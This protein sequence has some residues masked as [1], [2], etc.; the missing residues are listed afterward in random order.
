MKKNRFTRASMIC[1][2]LVAICSSIISPIIVM[3]CN[4]N[5]CKHGYHVW[6]DYYLE[7]SNGRRQG[8]KYVWISP[9]FNT[10]NGERGL[11]TTGALQWNS[12]PYITNYVKL[13]TTSNKSNAQIIIEIAEIGSG[14]LGI[15]YLKNNAL[16]EELIEV[17]HVPYYNFEG[18]VIRL[19]KGDMINNI[20]WL[21]STTTHEVG[22]ALGLGHNDCAESIMYK[23][24]NAEL[25]SKTITSADRASLRHIYC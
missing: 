20:S 25:F 3:A 6:N 23:T 24:H 9:E 5:K 2:S 10:T 14:F 7:S 15:T 8:T 1:A 21:Q 13:Q 19:S 11:V 16:T 17:D 12:I 4:E 18:A 22:H